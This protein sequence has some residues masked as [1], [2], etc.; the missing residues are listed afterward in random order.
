MYEF[1]VQNQITFPESFKQE[2]KEYIG[3]MNPKEDNAEF[4]DRK[5]QDAKTEDKIAPNTLLEM[6]EIANAPWDNS[7][8]GDGMTRDDYITFIKN[9]E[10]AEETAQQEPTKLSIP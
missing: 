5:Y 4:L 9:Q 10:L 1:E 6:Q 2:L 8:E 3:L 7:G